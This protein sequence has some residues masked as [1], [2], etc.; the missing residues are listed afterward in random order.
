MHVC[1]IGTLQRWF[2]VIELGVS[3]PDRGDLLLQPPQEEARID[4]E[5]YLVRSWKC[6]TWWKG[7]AGRRSCKDLSRRSRWHWD[8]CLPGDDRRYGGVGTWHGWHFKVRSYWGQSS[9][10]PVTAEEASLG[11]SCDKLF[12]LIS[13]SRQHPVVQVLLPEQQQTTN[14]IY[15]N[16]QT[17][18]NL[19]CLQ[20][21]KTKYNTDKDHLWRNIS[22]THSLTKQAI[23]SLQDQVW[24]DAPVPEYIWKAHTFWNKNSK[25][26]AKTFSIKVI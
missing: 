12:G 4:K 23:D 25:W 6:K 16:W 21:G 2:R 15:Q 3:H 1:V 26:P 7:S 10:S 9:G 13:R 11:Q 19:A 5:W 22:L 8:W 20:T 24:S 18:N 14:G 17:L